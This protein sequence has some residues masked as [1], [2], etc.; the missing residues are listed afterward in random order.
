MYMVFK[1]TMYK[2]VYGMSTKMYIVPCTKI[3]HVQKCIWSYKKT[4]Y[5]RNTIVQFGFLL[6][7]L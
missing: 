7:F 2:N 6:F 5:L 1:K 3:Y 4:K